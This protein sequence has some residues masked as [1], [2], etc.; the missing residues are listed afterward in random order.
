M[1][2]DAAAGPQEGELRG[3]PTRRRFL[4]Y[5]VAGAFVVAPVDRS[6]RRI[7]GCAG[8]YCELPDTRAFATPPGLLPEPFT[9]ALPI[10]G[11][12][13]PAD[14]DGDTDLYRFT[15]QEAE[16]PLAPGL[17]PRMLT[18]EGVFPG[19]TIVAGRD[20]AVIV[21]QH[22]ALPGNRVAVVHLHGAHVSADM[23]GHP[24]DLITNGATQAYR[25]PNRQPA[26]TLWYHDH[27]MHRTAEQVYMGLAGLYL[28]TDPADDR[29][30]L[31]GGERDIPLVLTDKTF[32][33]DGQLAYTQ[34]RDGFIGDALLVNGAPQPF[35]DVAATTYRLR[36]L[37]AANARTFHQLA[38]VHDETPLPVDL[39]ALDAGLVAQP[40]RLEALSLASAERA[41]VVIDF[42][43]LPVGAEVT[44][45]D[46]AFPEL[47]SR[48]VRFRV[49][50]AGP[51]GGALPATLASVPAL[52]TAGAPV[53][54]FV[55]SRDSQQRWVIDGAGFHRDRIDAFPRLDGV[56]V[57]RFR[58]D[59]RMVHP[60][61]L[62]LVSF[63]VLERQLPGGEPRQPADAERGWKD[64]VQVAPEETVTVAARFAGYTG[65]FVYHCHVLEHED[66]DM[67]SQFH[68]VDVRRLAGTNRVETAAA[69]SAATFAPEVQVAFVATA[70]GFADA[71]AGGPVAAARGG[72]MLLTSG[73]RLSTE[74]AAELDR[75]RPRRILVA[76]GPGAV[77][78]SV[79]DDLR[80]H[81]AG[82]V[83]R[84]AGADRYETAA[85]LSRA[86]FAAGVREVYVA[87]GQAFPDALAGGAAAAAAG[88]PV[89]LVGQTSVPAATADELRRLQPAGITLLGGPRAVA[90]AVRD[91]LG[92]FAPVT[93]VAGSSRYETAVAVSQ[94][95]FPGPVHTVHLATGADYPD[96]LAGVPAAGV[97]QGPL[98]LVPPDHIPEAVAAELRR[99]RPE[100]VLLLGGRGAVHPAVE[101]A[102]LR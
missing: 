72:P 85:A 30:A 78:D 20:R 58:N 67:M 37:N 71:L 79:L 96:A 82:T 87:T 24:L 43:G 76:G 97:G 74:T 11:L 5:A 84:I 38:F 64:T 39:I 77:P 15:M 95:A 4:Q 42:G 54:D 45:T 9:V 48:L 21:E 46:L 41:E 13:Q 66:H 53:R 61:H 89:L 49:T 29:L 33:A 100:R 62:H 3:M 10:P 99:L 22:N 98:L 93:R 86:Q 16:V 57:W 68:V 90:D 63:Q 36:L 18:Y 80:A 56:E 12:A 92:S 55:L 14:R 40:V 44:L 6:A 34:A 65:S 8:P 25:Y 101:E 31:P 91:E 2:P 81:T 50:S 1:A 26:A 88:G 28:L 94:R 59:S 35:H 75:L 19:P 51:A 17:A 7:E 83:E 32:T 69:V 73:T 70:Q 23:D 47:D 102:I 60:M 52:P 27:T